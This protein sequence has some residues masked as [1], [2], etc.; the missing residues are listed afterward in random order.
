ML[1]YPERPGAGRR[2]SRAC[3][4]NASAPDGGATRHTH[5]IAVSAAVVRQLVEAEALLGAAYGP[6]AAQVIAEEQFAGCRIQVLLQQS[7]GEWTLLV[8][9]L[10][11]L[12]AAVS[13]HADRHALR[14]EFDASGEARFPGIVEAWLT[15]GFDVVMTLGG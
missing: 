2:H 4:M 6:D 13:V 7:D 9:S 11:P 12:E 15:Q 1:R 8:R 5:I 3:P 14:Q 10:P